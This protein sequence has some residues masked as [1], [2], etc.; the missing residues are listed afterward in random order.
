MAVR[1]P[2]VRVEA[3]RRPPWQSR[4]H[5]VRMTP[6]QYLALPEEK[7]YLEY[8][9]GMVVQ[10]P[11]VN[12]AHAKLA[13]LLAMQLGLYTRRVG[14]G[15]V[16]VEARTA[17]G[18]LPNYRLPDVT[19]WAPGRPSGDDSLP[20]LAVEV[21]SPGQTAAE[22]RAKCRF[23]QRNGVDACWLVDP[24]A[25]TV[26][27]FEGGQDGGVL[28]ESATLT[29]AHLSGFALPLRELFAVLDD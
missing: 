1:Q 15:H 4:Y 10:K 22:L 18:S 16:G 21:R 13:A 26:E 7:P 14:G 3:P 28:S 11:M 8:V 23:F 17:V 9:D 27:V 20:T 25:R 5:G 19:Y 29:S 2:R 24:E 12:S 6:E